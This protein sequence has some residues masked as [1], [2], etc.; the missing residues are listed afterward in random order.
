M[1]RPPPRVSELESGDSDPRISTVLAAATALGMELVV[2]PAI[3]A[4]ELRRLASSPPGRAMPPTVL[5]ELLV[6]DGDEDG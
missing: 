2:V 1:G 5:E 4:R 3:K 6:P